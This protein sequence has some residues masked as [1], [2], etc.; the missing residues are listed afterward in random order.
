MNTEQACENIFTYRNALFNVEKNYFIK[1]PLL[2]GA[3]FSSR[4]S[5][6]V[7]KLSKIYYYQ[8]PAVSWL[9]KTIFK[10]FPS[11]MS[12]SYTGEVSQFK[13]KHTESIS[14]VE[15]ITNSGN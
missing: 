11:I 12:D 14:N 4:L 8:L 3:Q 1:P 13:I 6:F 15:G 5:N 2:K 9:L 7:H 10:E